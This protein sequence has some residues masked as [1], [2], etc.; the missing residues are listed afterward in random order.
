MPESGVMAVVVAGD[1][2]VLSALSADGAIWP[3]LL[4]LP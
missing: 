3:P 1:G 4:P 2:T